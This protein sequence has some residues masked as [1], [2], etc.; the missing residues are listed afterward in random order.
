MDNSLFKEMNVPHQ[1]DPDPFNDDLAH[2]VAGFN[3]SAAI[4]NIGEVG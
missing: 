4:T 3:Y 2:V 1:M